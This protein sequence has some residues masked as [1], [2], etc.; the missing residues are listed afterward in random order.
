MKLMNG[1][2]KVHNWKLNWLIIN[3]WSKNYMIMNLALVYLLMKLKDLMDYSIKDYKKIRNKKKNKLLLKF[4]LVKL[5]NL[6]GSI[7]INKLILCHYTINWK[8]IKTKF[9]PKMEKF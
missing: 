3:N 4:H 5:K 1:K 6:R 7:R 9:L 8:N 2:R